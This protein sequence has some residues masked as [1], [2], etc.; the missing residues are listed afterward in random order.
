MGI[1][2]GRKS[3]SGLVFAVDAANDRCQSR[4]L[5]QTPNWATTG[6]GP[7]GNTTGNFD[8]D[9]TGDFTRLGYGQTFGG[10]TIKPEDVVYRYDLGAPGCHYKGWDF[11]IGIGNYTFAF[12]YYISPD[13]ANFPT[14][15]LL[16]NY[17]RVIG[18]SVSVNG[19]KGV[20]Q[21]ASFGG[22]HSTYALLRALL[23][24]GACAN[25]YLAS[26]GYILYKNPRVTVG[27]SLRAN[28]FNESIG[29]RGGTYS[30]RFQSNRDRMYDICTGGQ[31]LGSGN[32]YGRPLESP[33]GGSSWEFDDNNGYWYMPGAN[34]QLDNQRYTMEVWI[35]TN[36]LNQFGFWFEKG[37]VNTQYSLFQEGGSIVHRTFFTNLGTYDSLYTTT[38]SYL[39]TSNWF[40]VVATYDGVTKRTY[41]NGV[42]TATK[43]ISGTIATNNNAVWIGKYGGGGGYQYNGKLAKCNVYNR[44]ISANEVKQN[45][46]FDKARFGY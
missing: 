29:G 14:Q 21:T 11:N 34:T 17:E 41:V 35:K 26:S 3:P 16:A 31:F 8:V 7:S 44:A 12:D 40:H 6:E 13:A 42:E 27:N 10:Y 36:N 19:L 22:N 4:N 1:T 2:L 18:G 20:W 24:P 5:F 28:D 39:N 30:Y 37:Q 25:S 23:Y 43:N 9:G 45:F 33:E 32:A 15:S 46:D 38:A